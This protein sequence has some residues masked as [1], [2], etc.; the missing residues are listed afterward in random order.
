MKRGITISVEDN[1]IGLRPAEIK[2]VFDKYYRVARGNVHDV[3]GFGL[4][5]SYV[6]RIVHAHGGTIQVRSEAGQGSAFEIELPFRVK[7]KRLK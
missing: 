1:G 4:G 6:K 2:H 5:L 7:S 3:K